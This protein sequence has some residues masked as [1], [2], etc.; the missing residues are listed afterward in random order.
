MIF[1]VHVP[2]PKTQH[3]YLDAPSWYDAREYAKQRW[4][5]CTVRATWVGDT[6]TDVI[7]VGRACPTSYE[8]DCEVA[9]HHYARGYR[10]GLEA[11]EE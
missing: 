5:G 2:F 4:P 8:R 1:Q 9:D 11:R 10:D 3:V 7:V 6:P